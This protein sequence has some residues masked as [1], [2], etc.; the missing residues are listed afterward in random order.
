MIRQ[1]DSPRWQTDEVSAQE[2]QDE[3]YIG[4]DMIIITATP[5]TS[6]NYWHSR[7]K[8]VDTYL[9]KGKFLEI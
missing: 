6:F 2:Y 3:T 4:V 8:Q 5:R 7:V 9:K 1:V